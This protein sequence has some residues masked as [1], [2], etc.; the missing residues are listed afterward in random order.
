MRS[1]HFAIA[2]MGCLN[3]VGNGAYAQQASSVALR[4]MAIEGAFAGKKANAA[5]ELIKQNPGVTDVDVKY[6]P[7]WVSAIPSKPS[8]I[9]VIIEKPT[10]TVQSNSSSNADTNP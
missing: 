8:K 7:F 2:V 5:K 10:K 3:C 1:I 9:T 6:S 4:P